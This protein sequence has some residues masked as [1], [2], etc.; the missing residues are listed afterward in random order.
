MR[1]RSLI[2]L[3]NL[4]ETQGLEVIAEG[5]SLLVEHVETFPLGHVDLEEV[6]VEM[7]TLQAKRDRWM[8]SQW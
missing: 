3:L 8:A 1:A 6:K 5:L 7:A 4:P 2:Q